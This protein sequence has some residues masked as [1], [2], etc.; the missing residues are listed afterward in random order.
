MHSKISQ[1]FEFI[2]VELCI[3]AAALSAYGYLRFNEMSPAAFFSSAAAFFACAGAYSYNNTADVREDIINR[4]NAANYFA[5]NI[6]GRIISA[7]LF[8]AGFIFSV[9]L[10]GTAVYFYI[11][12]AAAGIAYSAFRLKKY[13]LAKNFYA[14]FGIMLA[15][16]IGAANSPATAEMAAQ[17]IS[18]SAFIFIGSVISDLRDYEGDKAAGIRTIPVVLGYSPAKNLAFLMLCSYAIFLMLGGAFFMLLP[19]LFAMSAFLYYDRADM[20]HLFGNI[21]FIVLLLRVLVL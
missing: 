9:Y 4:K 13:F 10:S 7:A 20:A 14:G 5:L 2:R 16:L 18:L 21:S 8:I 3:F 6:S 17:Y 12:S 19:F 15:F 1:F 11:A